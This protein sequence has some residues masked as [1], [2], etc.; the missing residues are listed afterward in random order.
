MILLAIVLPDDADVADVAAITA[1]ATHSIQVKVDGP[2][3]INLL[4]AAADNLAW[5]LKR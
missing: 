2:L 1:S 5:A 3:D 4:D